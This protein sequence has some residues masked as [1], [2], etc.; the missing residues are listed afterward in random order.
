MQVRIAKP[1]EIEKL[2][3]LSVSLG[4]V[5]FVRDQAIVAV[6]E[7][8]EKIV[9]FAAVQHALHAAGSWIAEKQR[10]KKLSY[11]LRQALDNELRTRGFQFYFAIPGS[12]FEKHLFA[13]Y[14]PVTEHLVQVRQL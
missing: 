2:S 5:P 6:L 14:G 3:Q 9:G 12:D 10:K 4:N 13:K 8:E 11:Q 1:E 7:H